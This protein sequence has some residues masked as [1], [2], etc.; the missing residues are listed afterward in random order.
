MWEAHDPAVPYLPAAYAQDGFVH[1]TDGDEAMVAVA[2]RFYRDDPRPFLLLTLD[3]ERTGSPWRFDDPSGIYPHVYG[4]IDPAMR[5]GG[6]PDA[7]AM[8]TGRSSGSAR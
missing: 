4:S 6:P 2:N 8:R 5:A 3:L 7:P 1:C